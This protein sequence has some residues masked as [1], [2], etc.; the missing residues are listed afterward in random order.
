MG[1][2]IL[3]EVV[4]GAGS[5]T[6]SSYLGCVVKSDEV[7]SEV[8]VGVGFRLRENIISVACVSAIKGKTGWWMVCG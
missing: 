1:K 8:R 2:R 4:G 3:D 6:M 5:R 7:E